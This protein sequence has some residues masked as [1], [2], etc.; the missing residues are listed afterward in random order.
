MSCKP[1]GNHVGKEIFAAVGHEIR[2]NHLY[3]SSPSNT[4]IEKVFGEDAGLFPRKTA[5][6]EAHKIA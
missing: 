4:I 5:D 6:G 2:Y 3:V 1:V